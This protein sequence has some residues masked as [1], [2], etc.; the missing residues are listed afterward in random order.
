MI[1]DRAHRHRIVATAQK[2]LRRTF[3]FD[4]SGGGDRWPVSSQLWSPV[5][6]SLAA[7]GPI[8]TRADWLVNNSP[9]GAAFVEC[10]VSSLG[11]TGPTVRCGHPDP[12]KRAAIEKAWNRFAKRCDAEGT[13][14]L[15]G[16]LAKAIRILVI[17]GDA[18]TH[19][20]VGADHQLKLRLFSTEQVWR[21]YTRVMPDGRRIFSGVEVDETGRRIAYWVIRQQMD[22]PWAVYPLPDRISADD[23][24]HVFTPSFPGSVRGISW[25][26]AIATRLL[27]LD[28]LEDAAMARANTAA[29]FTGWIRDIDNT[30]GFASDLTPGRDGKP[31]LSM[32]PGELRRLPPGTDI[33][34]PSNIPDMAGLSDF[35][36]HMLRSIASG[37]GVPATLLTGDLSDVNYS[38]ARA[39]LEQFKRAVARLQQSNLVAQL[40]QPIWER[41]VTLEVLS[42][43]LDADDFEQN[44]DDYFDV[45]FRWPAWA[46]LDPGKDADADISLLNSKLRSRAEII[47]ARGRDI[48]DVDKE[49]EADPFKD[50]LVAANDNNKQPIAA[51]DNNKQ[52]VPNASA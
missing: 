9:T 52:Q 17:S 40:L 11:S 24:L 38:S 37:G 48:E 34:F 5:S 12:E 33:V 50:Q 7:A 8:S 13:G 27:E 20:V 2:M 44:A 16:Y 4:A 51:N 25:L 36:K 46:S 21:P 3:G 45:E 10:W 6:Q 32:E 19:M 29:L 30:S 1:F 39:G 31:Q 43:R 15:T 14:D 28:R 41:F 47:A 42:G 26:V 49:I 35:L 22:L 23:L 18:F